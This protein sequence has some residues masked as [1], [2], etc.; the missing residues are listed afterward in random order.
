MTTYTVHA[1]RDGEHEM[2]VGQLLATYRQLPAA[3]ACAERLADHY[4]W[5]TVVVDRE[6]SLADWGH[7]WETLTREQTR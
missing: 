6:H 4:Q 2:G 7:G 5:G 3:K 1:I